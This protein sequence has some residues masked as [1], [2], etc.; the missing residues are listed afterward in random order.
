MALADALDQAA[1]EMARLTSALNQAT[2]AQ[3]RR[4]VRTSVRKFVFAIDLRTTSQVWSDAI[5]H[6][7]RMTA[8]VPGGSSR[9]ISDAQ[10][11]G[12]S[13]SRGG[14][15]GGR[16][17]GTPGGRIADAIFPPGGSLSGAEVPGG[18]SLRIAIGGLLDMLGR[19]RQVGIV[20]IRIT[21]GGPWA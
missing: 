20:E 11:P 17:T 4:R 9:E 3:R 19:L 10:V 7:L 2:D 13:I 14:L 12:G 18:S 1:A 6:R 5:E 8:G 15:P 21:K 16:H